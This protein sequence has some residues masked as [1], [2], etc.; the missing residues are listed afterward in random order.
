MGQELVQFCA[1]RTFGT[2]F[3]GALGIKFATNHQ[4]YQPALGVTQCA[5]WEMWFTQQKELKVMEMLLA[6]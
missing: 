4:F 5:G 6:Q 3:V 1:V 2:F